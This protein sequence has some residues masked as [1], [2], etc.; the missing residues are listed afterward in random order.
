MA[1]IELD[2]VVYDLA[3]TS[4]SRGAKVETGDNNLEAKSGRKARDIKGT[5]YNYTL[6]VDSRLSAPREYDAF[7]EAITAPVES[8]TLKVPYGQSVLT[9]QACVEDV[10]DRLKAYTYPR[11]WGDLSIKFTARDIQRAPEG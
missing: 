7:Y 3:V 10:S 8:H 1:V 11:R 4:I 6:T 2:G 9:F 5:R